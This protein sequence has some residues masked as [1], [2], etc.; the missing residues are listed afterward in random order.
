MK[1]IYPKLPLLTL[2]SNRSYFWNELFL[3][4]SR[5]VTRSSFWLYVLLNTGKQGMLL[6]TVQW[7]LYV[8]WWHLD[9]RN[10]FTSSITSMT[11]I[12]QNISFSPWGGL[13]LTDIRLVIVMTQSNITI[14]CLQCDNGDKHTL[15]FELTKP[16]QQLPPL[17]FLC[18]YFILERMEHGNK[19]IALH[20]QGWNI[21]NY[22][23]LSSMYSG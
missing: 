7:P 5:D 19:R 3:T 12:D 6:R 18:V 15:Y 2:Y 4:F 21:I 10:Q 17:R 1:K 16:T 22:I 11:K 8:N 9:T 13:R 23:K 20:V 14:H